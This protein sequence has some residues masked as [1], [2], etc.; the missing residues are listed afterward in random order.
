MVEAAINF[1]ESSTPVPANDNGVGGRRS[2]TDV[3][4]DS[5]LDALAPGDIPTPPADKAKPGRKEPEGEEPE[6]EGEEG[7]DEAAGEVDEGEA[8][9]EPEREDDDQEAHARGSKE[10]PFSVKDLPEDRFIELKID[11]EK[12]TVSLAELAKGYIREATFNQRINRTQ[13][14]T[15]QAQQA[16]EK[17]RETQERVRHEFVSFVQDP[18]QIYE[19]FLASDD[20]EQVLE[21]VAMK[22]ASLL[23]RFREAPHERL[24][25]QRQRDQERL[26][27]E[28]EHWEAEKRAEAEARARAESHQ[29]A[30][31]VFK[32]GWE[33]G[34]RKAGFPEPVPELYE[35]VLVRCRQRIQSGQTVT[36]EDIADFVVRAAKTLEL[37]P[38]GAKRPKP[39]AL[40]AAPREKKRKKTQWDEMPAHK[41]AASPDYFLRNLRPRDFSLR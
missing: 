11:G 24:A 28:R 36:S 29:R 13:A 16:L 40:P 6:E 18:D 25:F 5:V 20:R 38:A 34:L 23:K 7:E 17:A 41:R 15:A 27:A 14:L 10:E 8:E 12:Q 26:R 30:V 37:P 4:V 35:E 31:S 9:H 19:F 21:Q 3:L 1:E 32:P 2:T 39:V 22:Y 33:A